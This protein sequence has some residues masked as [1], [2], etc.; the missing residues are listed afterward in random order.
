M[1]ENQSQEFQPQENQ[2]N[3]MHEEI[4]FNPD[5]NKS[6]NNLDL[7]SKKLKKGHVIFSEEENKTY[8]LDISNKNDKMKLLLS[9][10]DIFPA[11]TY[12]RTTSLKDLETKYDF[13]SN[14]SSE[15]ELIEELKKTESDFKFNIKKKSENIITLNISISNENNQNI[16]IDLNENLIDNRELFRQ[17]FEKFKSIQEEQKDDINQFMNRINK[18]EEIL[19]SQMKKEE[20]CEEEKKGEEEK[21]EE[22]KGEEGGKNVDEQE[23]KQNEDVIK[24]EENDEEKNIKKEEEKLSNKESVNSIQ[25]GK[26]AKKG[27]A[28]KKTEK[29]KVDKKNEKAD[30]IIGKGKF[31]KKNVKGKVDK[32]NE[33]GNLIKKKK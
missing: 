18:I 15:Q 3:E 1:S 13:L 20:Q 2:E 11:K 5:N 27:K 10:Q 4:I 22:E 24:K 17:L 16:E 7:I 19:G 32:K 25:K 6:S 21:K 29:G 8:Y 26:N 14:F 33:K 12:E 23:Q 30:K 31:D 28:D 9:E